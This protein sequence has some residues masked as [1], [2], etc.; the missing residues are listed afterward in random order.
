[1]NCPENRGKPTEVD[2]HWFGYSLLELQ[3]VF[4]TMGDGATNQKELSR[5][6]IADA[7][8]I[9]PPHSMQST[10]GLFAGD[11]TK[12]IQ[13]L[14]DQN[15]KLAEALDLLLPHLMCGEIPV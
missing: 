1:M 14:S 5:S 3:P 12:Q 8:V 11:S 2:P 9:T 15:T 10:F 4:E 7:K 13:V 6:R